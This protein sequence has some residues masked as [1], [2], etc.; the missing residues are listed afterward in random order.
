V[1]QLLLGFAV[2]GFA[3][4][5]RGLRGV[6]EAALGRYFLPFLAGLAGASGFLAGRPLEGTS[7]IASKSSLVYKASCE[8]GFRPA[9]S[10]RFFTVARG[11]FNAFAI[12]LTVMPSMLPSIGI[13]RNFIRNVNRKRH[14]GNICKVKSKK[15]FRKCLFLENFMLTK[16]F[17]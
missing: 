8:K 17:L 1:I 7:F 2:L 11:M 10:R 5:C 12:S 3:L 13:L 14:L 16:V 15:S 9:L 4:D 6:S